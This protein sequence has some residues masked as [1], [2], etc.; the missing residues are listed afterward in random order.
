MI[1]TDTKKKKKAKVQ[2]HAG[3]GIFTVETVSFQTQRQD[4]RQLVVFHTL[5]RKRTV[6]AGQRDWGGR[7][8]D[9]IISCLF[10]SSVSRCMFFFCF[11]LQSRKTFSKKRTKNKLEVDIENQERREAAR[12]GCWCLSHRR[13]YRHTYL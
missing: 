11:F 2:H 8:S 13:D 1:Y 6:G 3:D 4:S 5:E 10:S 12:A 9:S 7:V